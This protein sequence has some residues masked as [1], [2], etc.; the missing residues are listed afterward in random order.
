[1]TTP[2]SIILAATEVVKQWKECPET[3][4]SMAMDCCIRALSAALSAAAPGKPGAVPEGA[5]KLDLLQLPPDV[6]AHFRRLWQFHIDSQNSNVIV[7]QHG[8]PRAGGGV[9]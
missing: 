6:Q 4:A 8:A 7:G 2:D 3:V 5:A 9:K 1:M